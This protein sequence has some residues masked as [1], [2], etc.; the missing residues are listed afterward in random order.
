ME[1]ILSKHVSGD[2]GQKSLK[3]KK[4]NYLQIKNNEKYGWKSNI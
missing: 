3:K 4:K 2:Q 1:N